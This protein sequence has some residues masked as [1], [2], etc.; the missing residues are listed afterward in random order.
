MDAGAEGVIVPN[1]CTI[2]Q[3]KK[4]VAATRYPPLGNRGVGLARAQGYGERFKE[5]LDWQ[6]NNPIVIVQIE[7]IEAMADLKGIFNVEGVDG[8]MIGPYDLSASMGIAG[9]FKCKEFKDTINFILKTGK[10]C[11]L[12]PGIHIVEPDTQLLKKS[13][14]DGFKFIAYSVDIRMIASIS[15]KYKEI[16]K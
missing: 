5:Y 9:D 12:A 7:N 16:Y 11:G 10:E 15:N 1:I 2:N 8:F 3:A 6:K 4:A 14:S 13:I